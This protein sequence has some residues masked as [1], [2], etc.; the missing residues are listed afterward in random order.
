MHIKHLV[1]FVAC[2]IISISQTCHYSCKTCLTSDYYTCTLCEVGRGKNL[3]PIYGMCYCSS[4]TDEDGNGVCQQSGSYNT[5]SK[6]MIVLFISFTLVL[7][8]AAM[9]IK[10]NKYFLYKTI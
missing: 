1:F 9:L 8:V 4:S 6:L 5:G 10:G 2:F 3:A 7:S